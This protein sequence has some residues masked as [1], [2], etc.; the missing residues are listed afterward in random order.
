MKRSF[1]ILFGILMAPFAP[2]FAA[3]PVDIGSR[4]QLLVDDHLIEKL[5]G[6]ARL[7]L[8]RP[9]PKEIV[10]TFDKPWEGNTSIPLN[11]IRDGDNFRMYYRAENY[12]TLGVK[13]SHSSFLCMAESKNGIEWR[14]PDL[15]LVEFEGSKKNNIVKEMVFTPFLDANPNAA[16]EARYKG[17]QVTTVQPQR[18]L[19]FAHQSPD[20]IHWKPMRGASIMTN[21]VTRH[22]FDTVNVAFWDKTRGEY[23]AYIRDWKGGRR[24][25]M[26]TTSQDFLN[27]AEPEWLAYPDASPDELYTNMVLPYERSPELFIGFPARY[28]EKRG[29]LVEPLFMTSRDGKSFKLWEESLIRPGRSS[30]RWGNRCNYIWY[31]LLETASDFPGAPME[32]SLFSAEHYYMDGGVK[33]RRFTYRPDGFVSVNAP[34]KGGELLTKPLV[35]EGGELEIN[36][37]TSAAGGAR[38]EILNEKGKPIP[39]FEMKDC[40]EIFGD[41]VARRIAWKGAPDLASLAGKLIRLRVALRDADLFSFQFTR[42]E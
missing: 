7:K 25:I 10:M 3:E 2:S 27:W 20:G 26:T 21:G 24:G 36:V 35:F 16:P 17:F 33:L 39:G 23:R 5:S 42:S 22:A 11:T 38:V 34:W 31:G 6:G 13:R 19:L 14:R 12:V 1:V 29:S 30:D 4:P 15:G 28:M 32:H 18:R 37:S 9:L 8:H 41:E 40:A